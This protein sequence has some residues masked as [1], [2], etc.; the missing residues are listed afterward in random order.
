MGVEAAVH[1]VGTAAVAATQGQAAV[2]AVARVQLV[3]LDPVGMAAY[4]GAAS[5]ALA[6][7]VAAAELWGLEDDEGGAATAAAAA[8]VELVEMVTVAVAVTSLDIVVL[9]SM[10]MDEVAAAQLVAVGVTKSTMEA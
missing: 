3:V 2:V 8:V 9:A 6:V 4:G 10:E 7:E 1:L 5:A